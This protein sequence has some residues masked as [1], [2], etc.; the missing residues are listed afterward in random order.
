MAK[1]GRP[2][3]YT[4]ELGE[5]ICAAIACSEL[6]LA[7]LV[8]ANPHWPERSTIF[9]WRRTHAD[10]SDKYTK[11][12]EDQVEVSVEYMQ[13]LMNEPHKWIDETGSLKLDHNM[14]RMKMDAI[15]WQAA[16]LKPRKFGD[17]KEQEV[18]NTEVNDDCKK[19]YS[20]LD[21]KNRKDY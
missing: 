16:K 10:F 8:N 2:S 9:L 19:R 15:K 11:A 17:A 12:K 1:M 20:E 13:E 7:H 3:K 5:E 4:P 14:M 18:I 6:G 21:S